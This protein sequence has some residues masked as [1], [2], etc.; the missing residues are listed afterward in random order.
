VSGIGDI[1]HVTNLVTQM[2][3]VTINHIE[4]DVG[5]RVAKM[6]LAADS[7]S[8]NVETDTAGHDGFKDFFLAYSGVID[9]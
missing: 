3:Q 4:R 9:F 2:G 1:A 6:A 8:A 5:A 7:G